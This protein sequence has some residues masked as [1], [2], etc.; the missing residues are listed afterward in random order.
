[1]PVL[2]FCMAA[3]SGGKRPGRQMLLILCCPLCGAA[4]VGRFSGAGPYRDS[5]AESCAEAGANRSGGEAA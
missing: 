5:P 1:M 2:P 4:S 3:R